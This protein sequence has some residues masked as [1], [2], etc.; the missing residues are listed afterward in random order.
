MKK[1]SLRH[2]FLGMLCLI[3]LSNCKHI[4]DKHQRDVNL[5]LARLFSRFQ[6]V[7]FKDQGRFLAIQ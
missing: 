3:S 1:A 2:P 4:L 5:D 7:I 6:L